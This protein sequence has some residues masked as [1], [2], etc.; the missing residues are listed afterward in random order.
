MSDESSDPTAASG[1]GDPTPT[2]P[3]ARV[4]KK[5]SDSPTPVGEKRTPSAASR[6][7]NG[8]QP[9][10]ASER[11]TQKP[12]ES[13][14]PANERPQK[15]EPS[16]PEPKKAEPRT[17]DPSKQ[18]PAASAAA[19][20]A[21]GAPASKKPPTG[22]AAAT[23]AERRT[24]TAADYARTT[25]SSPAAT[26]VIPAVK[27]TPRP[28]PAAAPKAPAPSGRRASLRL[29]RVEPWS[30]TKI[31]FAISVALMIVGVVAVTIF[32]TVLEVVG[33][34]DQINSSVTS[35]LSDDG[36]GFDITDYFGFTRLIGLTLVISAINVV[37]FTALATIGAYLYNLAAQL[38]GGAEVTFAEEN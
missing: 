28:K 6:A 35:V 33:V 14:K 10:S 32:W 1:A 16:R 34:W 37:L 24:L 38:L 27:D 9:A 23:E 12:A 22:G 7:L 31:A 17:V 19:K 18:Q 21:A 25:R 11:A 4:T 20:K 15:S 26:A 13:A 36:T 29:T 2:Q 3:I 5:P 8:A 30:V